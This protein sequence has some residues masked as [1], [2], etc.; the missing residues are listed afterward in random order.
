[1]TKVIMLLEDMIARMSKEAKEDEEIYE[2]MG[3]WCE[4][5]DEAETKSI[6]DAVARISGLTATI[7]EMT[8]ESARLDFEVSSL[9]KENSKSQQALDTATA[10]RTKQ[11]AEFNA[12]E[13][14]M[15]QS[16]T[17]PKNAVISL[18]KHNSASLLRMPEDESE[19]QVA[20]VHA[21]LSK[22]DARRSLR[23]T[24]SSTASTSP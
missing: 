12:E 16:I 11:L 18:S 21:Q 23:P 14:D 15:M 24:V 3:C 10:L 8:G 6:A 20:G 7:E 13:K 9:G 22:R 4:T 5:N 19:N 1:M 17:S 2:D